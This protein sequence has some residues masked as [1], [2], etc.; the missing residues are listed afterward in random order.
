MHTVPCHCGV[1]VHAHVIPENFPAYLG[2]FVPANWPSMVPAHECHR[3][4]MISGK[5]YRTVSDRCWDV[6]R[7]IEDMTEMGL[8]MQAI[9][10]M[11]ELLSYWMDPKDAFQLLRFMNEKIAEMVALSGGRLVGLGA[12]PLQDMA[13]ALAELDYV[14]D[15][16]GF[17][18]VEIGSN[19][20]GKP[21]GDPE[22]APFFEACEAKGVAVFVHALRPAG[23]ERLVGPAQL[24]QALGYPTDVGLAA[25][26]VLTSNLIERFPRLRIA[27]SHGGGTLAMLLPRLE[28]ACRVF[29][30]LAETVAGS[31]TE[32]ARRLFYDT[33]VFDD[34][35]LAHLIATF[36]AGQLMI[37][38][39]YPFAFR[40]KRPVARILDAVQD[41][42][43]RAQ[44]IGGT[45]ARFLGR[46]LIHLH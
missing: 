44:L 35:T 20:N 34:A 11:P 26:S 32:Q 25:A 27:F 3:H 19:I 46:P 14:V 4:V 7:R 1:D 30:A 8:A 13:L 24:Q 45:A 42:A 36:G 38:T 10:P 6:P 31:P 15:K 43:M 41:P 5:V 29:P 37:G 18:G 22:F 28:Q 9:S 16:L 17:A 21:P 39:D 23:M 12:V 2:R 33:L 40:D